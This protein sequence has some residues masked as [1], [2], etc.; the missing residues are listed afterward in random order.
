MHDRDATE[1]SWPHPPAQIT[2]APG[3]AKIAFKLSK[4]VNE[5]VERLVQRVDGPFTSMVTLNLPWSYS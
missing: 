2:D 3:K 1:D 5:L 4:D